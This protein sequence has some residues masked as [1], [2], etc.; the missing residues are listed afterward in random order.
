MIRRRRRK[1]ACNHVWR[2]EGRMS[3]EEMLL[4]RR[5]DKYKCTKCGSEKAA[6]LHLPQ[7]HLSEEDLKK[8]CKK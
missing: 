6:G 1:K 4:W 2:F 8:F 7:G 3:M 5:T